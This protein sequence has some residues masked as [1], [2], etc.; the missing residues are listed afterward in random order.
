M[1]A[2]DEFKIGDVGY[3]IVADST[4]TVNAGEIKLTDAKNEITKALADGK[5]VASTK[6]GGA[7]ANKTIV[8]ELEKGEVSTTGLAD[9]KAAT[10]AAKGS[11]ITGA[12]IGVG[13]SVTISGKLLSQRKKHRKVLK[14]FMMRLNKR[15]KQQ[16]QLDQVLMQRHT[17][18]SKM[19][20][21][22]MRQPLKQLK[23]LFSQQ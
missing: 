13:D 1:A 22:K 3:K 15:Q 18:L 21:M 6:L 17:R 7:A 11:G 4:A 5:Q 16:L 2:A 10:I 20:K 14:I 23:I 8:T 12:T 19:T 9:T